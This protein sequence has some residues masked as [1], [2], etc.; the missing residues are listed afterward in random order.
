MTFVEFFIYLPF[1]KT[2][3][4][5]QKVFCFCRNLF[6]RFIFYWGNAVDNNASVALVI[7]LL[8]KIVNFVLEEAVMLAFLVTSST[9]SNSSTLFSS[10]SIM[11][12]SDFIVSSLCGLAFGVTGGVFFARVESVFFL[13]FFLNC[14]H[15]S[16]G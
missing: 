2:K 5:Y 14:V 12:M 11:A 3:I 15:F 9:T 7:A 1:L 4:F 6:F 16:C 13:L 8:L 10:I